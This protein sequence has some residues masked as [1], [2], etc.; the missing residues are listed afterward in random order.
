MVWLLVFSTS[1]DMVIG[2]RVPTSLGPWI[3]STR[4]SLRNS[5]SEV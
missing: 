4:F 5:H 2:S 1:S 3:S